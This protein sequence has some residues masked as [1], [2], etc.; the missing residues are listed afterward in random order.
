MKPVYFRL[1]LIAQLLAALVACSHSNSGDPTAAPVGTYDTNRFWIFPNPDEDPATGVYTTNDASYAQA[2][3]AA[4]DPSN[5]RNTLANF[6]QQNGFGTTAANTTEV[7]VIFRDVRDLGYGR[8]M[9]VRI[10]DTASPT[11]CAGDNHK[12]AVYVG[13]YQVVPFAGDDYTG[14]NL[15]AAIAADPAWHVGTNAIEYQVD[16]ATCQPFTRFYT[17][18]P[19][20]TRLNTVN[21]DGR[22]QKAMPSV[23]INCHGGRADPLYVDRSGSP[24]VRFPNGGNV[25]AR[26]QPIKVD[27]VEFAT[28]GSYTRVAQ[29]EAL[30]Q[31]NYAVYCAHSLAVSAYPTPPASGVDACR[32][33]QGKTDYSTGGNDYQGIETEMMQSWYSN[34]INVPGTAMSDTYLPPGPV[35]GTGWADTTVAARATNPITLVQQ[36]S[37]YDNVVAPYCRV[38]HALRGTEN[39]SDIDFTEYLKFEGYA[40]RIKAHV[41]DRGNMPLGLIIYNAFWKSTAPQQLADWLASIDPSYNPMRVG[42]GTTG[43]PVQPSGTLTDPPFLAAGATNTPTYAAFPKP[44]TFATIKGII[45]NVNT[46]G[47]TGCHYD[48]AYGIGYVGAPPIA[49]TDY[50]RDGSGSYVAAPN[51]TDT[52]NDDYAFYIALRGRVNLTDFLASPLL[53][54]PTGNHHGG[55][56]VLQKDP[57]DA[58]YGTACAASPTWPSCQPFGTYGAYSQAVYDTFLDWIQHGAPFSYTGSTPNY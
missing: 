19:D 6:K 29:E 15:D 53:R 33:F 30:R 8:R 9:T 16:P 56:K 27:S 55:G 52:A 3:Y 31:I 20:G 17:Y 39:Q 10:T 54:K 7:Q 24:T 4:I 26:M 37:L 18:A 28:S 49:Y 21:L 12:V 14:L 58:S 11:T 35:A 57:T 40:D 45:Q 42:G 48:G 41:F 2:Y 5:L 13:N 36:K 43:Q 22:G 32:P 44:T 51:A 47:C 46:V 23:C 38:C 1:A 50:D 25:H 34:A